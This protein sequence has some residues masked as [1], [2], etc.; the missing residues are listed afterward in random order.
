M[1]SDVFQLA[2]H[3]DSPWYVKDVQFNEGEKRLDVHV[4]FKKG[5][6]FEYTYKGEVGKYKAYDTVEKTW[7]HLNFFEHETYIHAR[8]PRI[9]TKDQ[10]VR[11]IKAP[12]EGVCPGF[13]LMF[14]SLLLQLCTCMTVQKVSKITHI[15]DDKLWRMLILYVKDAVRAM[16]LSG[17]EKVGMDET[18]RKKGHNYLTLFVDMEKRRTVFVTEGK[19]HKTVKTFARDVQRRKG[20]PKKI[21]QVCCDMSPA[22][23]KGIGEY[24][25]NAEITFDKFHLVINVNKAVDAVRKQEARETT[26]LK[27]T[28]YIFLKNRA[29]L[30][31][32]EQKK[33]S[34][35]TMSKVAV[36]TMRAYQIRE[37][38]QEIYKADSLNEF[39]VLIRKWYWRATHS[40]LRP[41]IKVAHM[42]KKHWNGIIQWRESLLSNGILEGFNS[43][44]QAA[45]SKARGFRSLNYFKTIIYLLTGKLDLT[46]NNKHYLPI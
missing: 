19:K 11:L 4:D 29:N 17:L 7:R 24:L 6:C 28:K 35:I 38:F 9:Q 46:S 21:R 36:K 5:S 44:I 2:L 18:N 42:I 20:S 22:F 16:D 13:T 26:I 12:W 45:K 3:I 25:P 23:I 31:E 37:T 43:L 14:E 40:R 8:V 34:E 39:K 33:L 27:G 15:S 30:T 10:K 1:R 32:I 41:I